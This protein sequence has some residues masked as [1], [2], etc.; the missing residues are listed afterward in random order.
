[1][2]AWKEILGILAIIFAGWFFVDERYVHAEQGEKTHKQIQKQMIV[3]ELRQLDAKELETK[4]KDWEKLRK[5]DL[6]RTLKEMSK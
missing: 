3:N 2:K 6:E 4:L 5:K 1:M